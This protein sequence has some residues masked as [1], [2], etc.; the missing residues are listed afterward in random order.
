[1]RDADVSTCGGRPPLS[2]QTHGGLHGLITQ[3][4]RACAALAPRTVLQMFPAYASSTGEGAPTNQDGLAR[5]EGV[6]PGRSLRDLER[7]ARC[8]PRLGREVGYG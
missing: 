1:M 7:T 2:C 6:P 4:H 5:S 8:A 3:M